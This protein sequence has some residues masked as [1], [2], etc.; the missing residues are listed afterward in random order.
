MGEKKEEEK[1]PKSSFVTSQKLLPENTQE[2]PT[3]SSTQLFTSHVYFSRDSRATKAR[4]RT[5][6]GEETH[7]RT[8]IHVTG[9]GSSPLGSV[10]QC[11]GLETT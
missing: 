7:R 9:N 1:T 5:A 10:L 2:N 4:W 8:W 11:G 3:K 6:E